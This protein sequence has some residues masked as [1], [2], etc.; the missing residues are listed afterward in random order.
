[1]RNQV[2]LLCVNLNSQTCVLHKQGNLGGRVERKLSRYQRLN[3]GKGWGERLSLSRMVISQGYLKLRT[4][5]PNS[6]MFLSIYRLAHHIVA[7]VQIT[8]LSQYYVKY[9]KPLFPQGKL[10]KAKVLR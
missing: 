4:D 1:M 3:F 7:R 9:W 10:V 5:H 2:A 8:N 6:C